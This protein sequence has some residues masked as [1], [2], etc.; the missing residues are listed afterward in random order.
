MNCPE[1][2][3]FGQI[4][5]SLRKEKGFSQEKLAELSNLDT[6]YISM[7]ERAV[8]VPTIRTIFS[9]A[10]AL[11]V[12]ASKLIQMVEEKKRSLPSL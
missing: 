1:S 11:D 12:P 7:I 8:R 4:V 2:V 3:L 10:Q 6:T 9:I 5:R